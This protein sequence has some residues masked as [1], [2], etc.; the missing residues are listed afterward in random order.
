MGDPVVPREM[1]PRPTRRVP[2]GYKRRMRAFGRCALIVVIALA[3]AACGGVAETDAQSSTD[4]QLV[5]GRRT[6]LYTHCGVISHF[7]DGTLWLADPPL[8]DGSH[9]PPDGWDENTTQGTWSETESGR[10][11]F[12][13]DSGKTATFI[14]ARLGQKDPNKG[15]E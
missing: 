12:R 4:E 9:N 14:A 1:W 7:V 6:Q 15:C 8:H 5:E 10:A 3:C 2:L 13:S 11:V